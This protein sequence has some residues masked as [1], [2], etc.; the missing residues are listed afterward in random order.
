M[1]EETCQ[2]ESK[3]PHHA[4]RALERDEPGPGDTVDAV[5]LGQGGQFAR[6]QQSEV[7]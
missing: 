5:A 2:A 7:D 3:K 4:L 6:F 1:Q